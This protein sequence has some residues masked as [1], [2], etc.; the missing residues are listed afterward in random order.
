MTQAEVAAFMHISE[1]AVRDIERRAF[2]KIRR[3]AGLREFWREWLSGEVEESA[4]QALADCVLTRE[5]IT[6]VYALAQTPEERMA[7]TKLLVLTQNV[8]PE[9]SSGREA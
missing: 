9:R 5:E 8:S 4:S 1:R 7:L 3:H 6:A 2:D